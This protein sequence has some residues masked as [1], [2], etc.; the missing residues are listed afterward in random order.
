MN[1]TEAFDIKKK[2]VVSF[3]GGGGKT[4][5]MF[6]L[7]E[8]LVPEHSVLVTT[9]TKI[10]IPY[11]E[12]GFKKYYAHDKLD[13]IDFNR[14]RLIVSGG[15]EKGPKITEI[16][17]EDFKRLYNLV[18]YVLIEADGSR[19]KP[20]KAW[21]DF[22][23]VI[24]KET[25]K[26]IGVIPITGLLKELT[27]EDIFNFELF[28]EHFGY[29]GVFDMQ[30]LKKMIFEEYGIFKGAQ[31]SRYIYFNHCN[32]DQDI[33]KAKKISEELSGYNRDIKYVYGSTIMENSIFR[34]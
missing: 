29:E 13:T 20:Y 7:A 31:G 14:Y 9:T 30:V 18:D 11:I 23:P 33:I 15:P 21:R 17:D 27:E 19:M 4:T 25:T 3:V 32:N 22:E 5:A 8:E 28:K 26:T 12:T 16:R 24:R 1:L 6:H 2:D 10:G 34:V